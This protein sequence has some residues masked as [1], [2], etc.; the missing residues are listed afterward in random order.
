[1]ISKSDIESVL[2]RFESLW[3]E[4][5][6]EEAC[7]CYAEDAS[8]VGPMGYIQGKNSILKIVE[9]Y[10]QTFPDTSKMGHLTLEVLE[11]RSIPADKFISTMATALVR[12]AL[13]IGKES[14][15]GYFLG[16]YQRRGGKLYLV[17][18]IST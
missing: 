7:E 17:Q 2:K 11:V 15:T 12:W 1:M 9:N 8:S 6:L 16:V 4:G 18:D 14:R 13:H 5:K 3:N 10:L